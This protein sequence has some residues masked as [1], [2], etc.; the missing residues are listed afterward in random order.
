M[1]QVTLSSYMTILRLSSIAK[2][3]I[4]LAS[5][6]PILE[7]FPSNFVGQSPQRTKIFCGIS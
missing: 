7:K 1:L 3:N 6:M 4:T 5:D 2:Q